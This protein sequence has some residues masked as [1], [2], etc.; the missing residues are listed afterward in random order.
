MNRL[1]SIPTVNCQK[2][3]TKTLADFLQK[4]RQRLVKRL[5]LLQV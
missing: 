4:S 3:V 1:G 2:S 5:R